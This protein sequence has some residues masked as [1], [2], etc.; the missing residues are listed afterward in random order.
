[1]TGQLPF[2]GR[3][4][5]EVLNRIADGDYPPAA[6]ICPL[7]DRELEDIIALSLASDPD[8]RYQS[9]ETFGRELAAYLDEVGVEPTNAELGRYFRDPK[10]Y[11]VEL[12]ERVCRALTE[13]AQ[14]AADAGQT[15]RAIRLLGR[16]LELDG[17]HP[18]A[19]ELLTRLRQRERR[20]RRLLMAGAGVLTLGLV[21]LVAQLVPAEA[22]RSEDHRPRPGGSAA[23]GAATDGDSEAG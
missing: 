11:V 5:H 14:A 1:A 17:H 13:R 10:G 8:E 6:T 16:V 19:T 9:V 4:P 12:D 23:A 2:F 7:V 21:W 18:G 3:N 15:A 20:N 22:E